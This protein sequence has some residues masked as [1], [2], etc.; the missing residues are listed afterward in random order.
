[1]TDTNTRADLSHLAVFH[2]DLN[3]QQAHV[4]AQLSRPALPGSWQLQGMVRGPRN[5]LTRTLPAQVAL[6]DLGPGPSLLARAVLPDPC[7]WA[8][9]E[10]YVYDVHVEL[11]RDRQ[12]V[13]SHDRVLGLR[14][15]GVRE[16][17]LSLES[18]PWQL[19]GA[20]DHSVTQAN[21]DDWRRAGLARL[22]WNPNEP[23][24]REASEEGVM[25]IAQLA[26]DAASD[27]NELRAQ[28]ARLGA[29]AAVAMIAVPQGTAI[30]SETRAAAPNVLSAQVCRDD[31]HWIPEPGIDL[32]IC[33]AASPEGLVGRLANCRCP[34]LVQQPGGSAQPI[35]HVADQC[36]ALTESYQ[37]LP[38]VA[39]SLV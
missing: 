35:R 25:L 5:R 20:A 23:C 32:L 19:H 33:P 9:G 31:M 21:W 24:C 11:V 30:A 14:M 38:C 39:G 27:A 15:L 8:P 17:G 10:P 16:Q 22:V 4:Y 1:M 13:A 3:S 18:K 29:H 26:A 12:V 6:H 2:G 36:R 28:W 34:V 7:F 37:S